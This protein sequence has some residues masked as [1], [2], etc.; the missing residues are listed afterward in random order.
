MAQKEL[1]RNIEYEKEYKKRVDKIEY[2]KSIAELKKLDLEIEDMEKQA[3]KYN[4]ILLEN[5]IE[6]SVRHTSKNLKSAPI[7]EMVQYNQ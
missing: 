5:G 2:Q 4:K 7:P 6:V 1:C 3:D